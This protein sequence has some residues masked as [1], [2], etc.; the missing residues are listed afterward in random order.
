MFA[1]AAVEPVGHAAFAEVV[2]L[3]VRVE[4]QQRH[5]AHLGLPDPGVQSASAGQCQ[6]DLGR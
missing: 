2:L 3:D 4:Q 1:A 5:P 6:A